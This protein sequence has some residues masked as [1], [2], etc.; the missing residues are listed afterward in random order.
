[1]AIG[2]FGEIIFEVSANKILTF[3]NFTI[4]E[5]VELE[6]HKRI[7]QK[8]RIE[9]LNDGLADVSFTME[10]NINLGVNPKVIL[11]QLDEYKSNGLAQI[12][13]LGGEVIG[14]DRFIIS[15]LSKEYSTIY[16]NG[17]LASCKVDIKLKEYISS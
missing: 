9:F 8:P 6:E 4:S 10:L 2:Y 5:S 12:L 14:K 3:S 15:S 16:N 1:M 11:K 7:G 13:V 17:V